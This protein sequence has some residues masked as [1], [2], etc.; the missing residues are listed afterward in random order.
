MFRFF[1][2]QERCKDEKLQSKYAC[3][4]QPSA[5]GC[6]TDGAIN[7]CMG[8][9]SA[10]SGP[11]T[12]LQVPNKI[13]QK[14][15]MKTSFSKDVPKLSKVIQALQA[16]TV[17]PP[18]DKP[19]ASEGA[20]GE[21][22]GSRSSLVRMRDVDPPEVPRRQAPYNPPQDVA[23]NSG[24]LVQVAEQAHPLVVQRC[25]SPNPMREHRNN[26]THEEVVVGGGA[27]PHG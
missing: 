27:T 9:V 16:G 6:R 23:S 1:F 2:K 14:I 13:L 7:R 21:V 17:R 12:E 4:D 3:A 22:R 19:A 11:D 5:P 24:S 25:P 10:I 26:R 8:S 15:G 20:D 18:E